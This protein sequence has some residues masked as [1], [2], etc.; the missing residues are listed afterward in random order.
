MDTGYEAEEE[1]EEE[2]SRLRTSAALAAACW[3]PSESWCGLVPNVRPLPLLI[4][5]VVVVGPEA[6]ALSGRAGALAGCAPRVRPS[7][8]NCSLSLP[9][10]LPMAALSFSVPSFLEAFG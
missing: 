10:Q 5:V 4:F 9:Q 6:R 3:G 1:V 2:E 7:P 8:W